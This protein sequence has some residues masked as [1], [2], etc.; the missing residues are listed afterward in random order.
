MPPQRPILRYHGGKWLL[1]PFAGEEFEASYA[2]TTDPLK[3]ARRMV[4]R[5]LQSF[6]SAAASGERTG[7][8]GLTR[9][10][11]NA[12]RK[13]TMALRKKPGPWP[14]RYAEQI[15]KGMVSSPQC[16][17]SHLHENTDSP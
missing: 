16:T 5:S 12:V 15:M 11:S 1:A 17:H 14:S 6:G 4:V 2:E 9:V 8:A 3:R 7:F 13:R 10:K